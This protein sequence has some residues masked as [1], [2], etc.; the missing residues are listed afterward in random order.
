MGQAL[1]QAGMIHSN[2]LNAPRLQR[3][4]RPSKSGGIFGRERQIHS[5]HIDAQNA[6]KEWPSHGVMRG[7]NRSQRT[8]V[9]GGLQG[10]NGNPGNHYS[11]GP[12]NRRG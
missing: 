10:S 5:N 9:R 2:H 8:G 6:G 11:G 1:S 7:S 12:T 3:G 4:G